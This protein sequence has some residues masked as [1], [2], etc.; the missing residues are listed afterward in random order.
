MKMTDGRLPRGED[1]T[2]KA[3]N[4]HEEMNTMR[5]D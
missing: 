4:G 5:T 2:T 1:A 3:D